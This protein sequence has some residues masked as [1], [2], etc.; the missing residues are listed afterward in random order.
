MWRHIIINVT[1]SFRKQLDIHTLAL[2]YDQQLLRLGR[3]VYIWPDTVLSTHPSHSPEVFF[4]F[5]K[6]D[7]QRL[8]RETDVYCNAVDTDTF[9][10]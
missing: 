6:P 9:I 7:I 5:L 4:L 3:Y 10:S 8:R 2:Q 1:V